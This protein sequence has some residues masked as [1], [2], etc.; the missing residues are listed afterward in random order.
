MIYVCIMEFLIIIALIWYVR[1]QN[2]QIEKDLNTCLNKADSVLDALD[3]LKKKGT[4]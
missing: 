3:T 2:K 1:Q 4:Q